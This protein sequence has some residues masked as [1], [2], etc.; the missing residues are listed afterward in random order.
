MNTPHAVLIGA[1]MIGAAII[2][3]RP[4]VAAQPAAPQP[5]AGEYQI[6]P[7]VFNSFPGVFRVNTVTGQV[8]VCVPPANQGQLGTCGRAFAQQ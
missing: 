1:V 4:H 6:V 3:T 2:L 7:F 8:S 5:L